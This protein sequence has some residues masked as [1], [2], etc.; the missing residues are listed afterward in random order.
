MS[1]TLPQ[2]SWSIKTVETVDWPK[3][4]YILATK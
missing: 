4:K 1:E 2:L 3:S